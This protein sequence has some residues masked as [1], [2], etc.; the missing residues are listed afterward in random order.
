MSIRSSLLPLLPWT[1]IS[2][3][4]LIFLVLDPPSTCGFKLLPSALGHLGLCKSRS[5]SRLHLRRWAEGRE[6]E[7]KLFLHSPNHGSSWGNVLFGR[8]GVHSKLIPRRSVA[9]NGQD[10]R[11]PSPGSLDSPPPTLLSGLILNPFL[12]Q[13]EET[14]WAEDKKTPRVHVSK[15]LLEPA[16]IVILQ[17]Q[18]L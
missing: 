13:E 12:H 11:C 14:R 6:T 5:C 8:R 4:A 9:N 18:P 16:H 2:L 1:D 15:H 7:I 17:P 10:S 3:F